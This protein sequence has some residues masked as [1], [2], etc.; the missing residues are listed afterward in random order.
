MCTD[1]HTSLEDHFIKNA[2]HNE[3]S[4]S[5][6][7]LNHFFKVYFNRTAIYFC[8]HCFATLSYLHFSSFR[9]DN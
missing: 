1:L 9:D 7:F 2:T 5:Q 3:I 4:S 8:S 6:C